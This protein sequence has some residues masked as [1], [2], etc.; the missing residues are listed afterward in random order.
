MLLAMKTS[1][2]LD[3]DTAAEWK[4]E[5]VPLAELV[6]RGLKAGKPEPLDEKI[7]RVVREELAA[8]L[9][10]VVALRKLIERAAGET[11]G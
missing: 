8:V 7:A 3:D 1:V 10:E 6:K 4:A 11:H 9:D 5:N 2:W